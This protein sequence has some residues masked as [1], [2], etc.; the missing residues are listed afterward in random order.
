[1]QRRENLK[2][3]LGLVPSGATEQS[4]LLL[5]LCCDPGLPMGLRV[6]FGGSSTNLP[7]YFPILT[8]PPPCVT[9]EKGPINPK[10]SLQITSARRKL[11]VVVPLLDP[12]AYVKI[13]I[14]DKALIEKTG[15]QPARYARHLLHQQYNPFLP[16]SGKRKSGG[17]IAAQD[18]K[19]ILGPCLGIK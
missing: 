12:F 4:T 16:E 5:L 14:L 18:S 7:K 3:W 15:S 19:Y 8:F 11:G 9:R 13:I 1:M 17:K 2:V 10:G 6:P